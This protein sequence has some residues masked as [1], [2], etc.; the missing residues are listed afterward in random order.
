MN[1]T[2]AKDLNITIR[3]YYGRF[4][5]QERRKTVTHMLYNYYMRMRACMQ[6]MSAI[7]RCLAS[8]LRNNIGLIINSLGSTHG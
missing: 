6:H 1:V 8:L 3:D 7:C 4:R 5:E 2:G